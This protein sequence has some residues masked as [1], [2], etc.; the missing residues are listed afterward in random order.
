MQHHCIAQNYIIMGPILVRKFGR[1]KWV[2]QLRD[3]T[4]VD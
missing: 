2:K 1:Q 4:L 3:L